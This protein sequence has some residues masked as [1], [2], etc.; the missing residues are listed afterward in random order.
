MIA[1]GGEG[2]GEAAE[3]GAAVVGDLAGLA[4]HES[5]GADDLAS[6]GGADGLVS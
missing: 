1:G 4:V 6:E 5:V 2:S 3:D